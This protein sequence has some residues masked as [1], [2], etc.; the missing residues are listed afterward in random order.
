MYSYYLKLIRWLIFHHPL[1]VPGQLLNSLMLT[2]GSDTTLALHPFFM[3]GSGA[4]ANLV[5]GNETDETAMPN[6]SLEQ[7]TGEMM[8]LRDLSFYIEPHRMLRLTKLIPWQFDSQ[9]PLS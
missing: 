9:F 5:G 7:L 1:A 6:L 8:K 2:Y 3:L 4:N